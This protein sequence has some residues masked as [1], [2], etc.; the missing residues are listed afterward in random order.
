MHRGRISACGTTCRSRQGD[1]PIVYEDEQVVQVLEI[2]K[3]VVFD[4]EVLQG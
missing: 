3:K 2:R 1:D 4:Q